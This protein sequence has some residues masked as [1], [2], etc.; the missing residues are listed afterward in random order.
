MAGIR[1]DGSIDTGADTAATPGKE[2][3]D[4]LSNFND[5]W[6]R[7]NYG[8]LQDIQADRGYDHYRPAFEYGWNA[9][10]QHRGKQWADVESDLERDWATQNTERQWAEHRGAV[11]H[12][13]E[14]ALHVFEGAPDPDRRD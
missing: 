12:A 5:A 9:Y 1:P 4:I 10:G 8:E 13:F 3:R 7:D 11:R 14:R 6:W 2:H